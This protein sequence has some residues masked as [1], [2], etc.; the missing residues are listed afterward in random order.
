M[1]ERHNAILQRLSKAVPQPE[2]NRYLE[3]KL[4][5]MPGD[6]RPDLA[7]WHN[8]G[9]VTIVDVTIPYEADEAAFEKARSEKKAK[10]QPIAEWLQNNGHTDVVI[11]AFVV[12][13]LGSWDT[14]NET[15]LKRLNIG[16][17]YASLFRKLCSVDAIKGSL[18]IWR[19]KG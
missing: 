17:K 10:Y 14:N 15:V 12:G 16:P 3:Q 11:D 5:G 4:K 9:R 8:D 18:T 6:L 2:G 13:A 7:L 1:R 19:S